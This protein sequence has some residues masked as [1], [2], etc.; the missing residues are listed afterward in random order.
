MSDAAVN[1][2]AAPARSSAPGLSLAF[3]AFGVFHLILFHLVFAVGG[4]Q[5]AQTWFRSPVALVVT[6]LFT[7]GYVTAVIMG[8]M[9]QLVPVMLETRLWSYKLGYVQL[10]GYAAGLWLLLW[11]FWALDPVRLALAG[12]VLIVS[13]L[14]FLVNMALTMVR[15]RHW[16]PAAT[17]LTA[18]LVYLTA[19]ASWGLM[20]SL[21]FGTGF[22]GAETRSHL[23]VHA[24][25]GFGGWFTLTIIGVAYRLV[26]LFTLVHHRAGP[27][28]WAVFALVNTGIL[29]LATAISAGGEMGALISALGLLVAGVALFAW[30]MARIIRRR[31]RRDTDL[32][33]TG[34]QMALGWLLAAT[35]MLVALMYLDTNAG[36]WVSFIYALALGW[37]SISIVGQLYKIVPFLVWTA[38]FASRAGREK[39]PVL[40]DLYSEPLAHWILR[41]MASGTLL[42]AGGLWIAQPLLLQAGV[43]LN[44]VGAVLLAGAMTRIML[45]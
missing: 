13:V 45:A 15:R 42:A 4:E 37:V 34:L 41:L 1:G 27:T 35:V 2:G 17:F 25:L 30:E 6:H 7:L 22:L 11:G 10:L 39:V 24:L 23:A 29:G 18:S 5:I 14:L 40:R 26:P 20:L 8:A 16:H 43:L 3:L 38:R 31:L 33:L 12:T 36:E 44:L 19:V 28:T 32:G 21:N 9:Y